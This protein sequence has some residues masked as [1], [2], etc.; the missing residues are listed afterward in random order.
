LCHDIAS[1]AHTSIMNA[2]VQR[3][4]LRPLP[5]LESCSLLLSGIAL[6]HRASSRDFDRAHDVLDALVDRHPRSAQA[7][8]WLAKWYVLKVVR[9]MSA[10]PD[11]DSRIAIEQTERALDCEPDSALALA[12]QGHALCQLSRDVGGALGRINHAL[13]LSPNDPLAWL[14]KSVWSSMWGSTVDSVREAEVASRLSPVDPMKYYYDMILASGLCID[15]QYERA[16]E[17]ACRSL[18]ANKHHQ[19]T[20]RVLLFAQYEAGH[21]SEAKETLEL[22][23]SET[24]QLTVASYLGLGGAA[25]AP[26]Q[27]LALVLRQLGVAEH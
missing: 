16:I 9:G 3:A 5:T 17:L 25:S 11:R 10:A 7:R 27:K 6:T 24:P 13:E 14:Y 12:I 19:P 20:L 23:R 1:G 8:A 18:R 15:G 2:E 4:L 22:L 26:R 21:V